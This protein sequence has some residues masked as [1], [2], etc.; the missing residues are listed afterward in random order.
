VYVQREAAKALIVN[1]H[2]QGIPVLIE[3]L[4]FPSIDAF[5]HYDHELA[6][7]LSYYTGTD[8]S[9]DQR[10]AYATWMNWWHANGSELNL[11]RNLAIM[12]D[13][14]KAFDAAQEEKGIAVFERLMV[15]NPENVVVKHRYQRF[16]YEWI[17]FR[18]LTRA[19]ITNDV[20]RR[21][22]RLQKIKAQL[23][24]GN[25]QTFA[26]LAYFYARLQQFD[27]AIITLKRAIRMDPENSDYH[28]ALKLYGDLQKRIQKRKES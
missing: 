7:D 4:Q 2:K 10:Y 27:E 8:F 19:Q 13:I 21:C 15:E 22:L 18:L 25:P 9:G 28:R 5:E 17:T 24:P 23:E 14:Q 12:K 1:N 11:K 16:C 6:R 20:L 26:T 3:T